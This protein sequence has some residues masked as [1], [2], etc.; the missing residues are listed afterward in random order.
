MHAARCAGCGRPAAG[1][2]ERR[3]G[4]ADITTADLAEGGGIR[5]VRQVYVAGIPPLFS[6]TKFSVML[7]PSLLTT[8]VVARGRGKTSS[9]GRPSRMPFSKWLTSRSRGR[10]GLDAPP[11]KGA[12]GSWRGPAVDAL[13]Q[14][15]GDLCVRP[16]HEHVRIV[17]RL[18]GER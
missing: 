7:G 11:S 13:R 2:G 4:A 14:E 12:R 1:A 15:V 5:V 8:V 9:T 18:G 6:I 16:V 10:L 3:T 17:E